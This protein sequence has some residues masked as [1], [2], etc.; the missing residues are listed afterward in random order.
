MGTNLLFFTAAITGV[1]LSMYALQVE[2][3]SLESIKNNSDFT[4][5]CDISDLISCS[6]VFTS[7]Y[8]RLFVQFGLPD[9]PNAFYGLF[10]YCTIMILML[11]NS[12]VIVTIYDDLLLTL[13][14]ISMILSA[15]LAYVLANILHTICVVCFLSYIC[16]ACIFFSVAFAAS[17]KN[18]SKHISSSIKLAKDLKVKNK[19][20]R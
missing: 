3:E 8:G 15:Y 18:R 5:T 2:N 16:N 12:S 13:A 11:I 17:T 14:T 10:Y 9:Y 1:L 6:K 20:R 19:N 7:E 4:A